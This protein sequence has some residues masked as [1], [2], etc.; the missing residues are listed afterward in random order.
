MSKLDLVKNELRHLG[1]PIPTDLGIYESYYRDW[2]E[3]T[4]EAHS[5]VAKG[6]AMGNVVITVEH[7]GKTYLSGAPHRRTL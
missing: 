1:L 7:N 3:Q 5:Y 6:H 4:A 2:L